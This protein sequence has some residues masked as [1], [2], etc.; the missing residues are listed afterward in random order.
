MSG[1]HFDYACCKI[2]RLAEEIQHEIDINDLH[3]EAT[4]HL[5]YD[6]GRDRGYGLAPETLAVVQEIQR[7]LAAAGNLAREVEWLYSGDHGEGSFL[8]IV[9][10]PLEELRG[11]VREAGDA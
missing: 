1:G 11:I 4:D 7:V 6:H 2:S 8:E 9:R 5:D 3:G 10:D